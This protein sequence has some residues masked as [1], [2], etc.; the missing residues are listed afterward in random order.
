[1]KRFFTVLATLLVALAPQAASATA[2]DW[3]E[4]EHVKVRIV[5][6]VDGVGDR[7]S[8][9]LGLHFQLKPG[10]K[11]YWRSPGDAGSFPPATDANSSIDIDCL[12]P[13]RFRHSGRGR[14]CGGW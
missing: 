7:D 9:P 2:S 3:D 12:Q 14:G 8:I 10:W 13:R 4:N 5:S 6:A 1:M 11:I